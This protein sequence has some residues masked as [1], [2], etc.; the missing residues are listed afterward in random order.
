MQRHW[1]YL[2]LLHIHRINGNVLIAKKVWWDRLVGHFTLKLE[3]IMKNTEKFIK[4]CYRGG[5]ECQVF[6]CLIERQEIKTTNTN[7]QRRNLISCIHRVCKLQTN[8]I[9][10]S[11]HLVLQCRV[12]WSTFEQL[13]QWHKLDYTFC[14]TSHSTCLHF[15]R[16]FC[17]VFKYFSPCIG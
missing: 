15:F 8:Q 14:K 11:K 9:A 2:K 4:L 1:Y 7:Q 10:S 16:S 6:Y 13:I 17:D 12:V 3:L 5:D